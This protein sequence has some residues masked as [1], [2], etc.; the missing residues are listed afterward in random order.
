MLLC[1]LRAADYVTKDTQK[2]LE[3][4]SIVKVAKEYIDGHPSTAEDAG[5]PSRTFTYLLERVINRMAGTR[6]VPATMV[7]SY[8]LQYPAEWESARVWSVYVL[9]AI[10]DA[11]RGR[12]AAGHLDP[13]TQHEPPPPPVAAASN[14]QRTAAAIQAAVH[15]TLPLGGD[16]AG[17]GDGGDTGSGVHAGAPTTGLPGTLA[18]LGSGVGDD[19]F[20][21]SCHGLG[22]VLAGAELDLEHE[23]G[24]NGHLTMHVVPGEVAGSPD[25]DGASG[26]L[27]ASPLRGRGASVIAFSS[28]QENYAHRGPALAHLNFVEYVAIIGVRELS[29]GGPRGQRDHKGPGRVPNLEFPFEPGHKLA[30]TCVQYLLSLPTVPLLAGITPPSLV[31]IPALGDHSTPA[32]IAAVRRMRDELGA[33]YL[34]IMVPWATSALRA[35]ACAL[36]WDSFCAWVRFEYDDSVAPGCVRNS[37][38]ARA[39]REYVLACIQGMSCSSLQ[40]TALLSWR[41]LCADTRTSAVKARVDALG[42]TGGQSEANF[43]SGGDSVDDSKDGHGAAVTDPTKAK[44]MQSPEELRMC[45]QA[46][47]DH[48][49]L[50]MERL[51]AEDGVKLTLAEAQHQANVETALK[52]L[53]FGRDDGGGSSAGAGSGAGAGGGAQDGGPLP[54]STVGCVNCEVVGDPNVLYSTLKAKMPSSATALPEDGDGAGGAVDTPEPTSTLPPCAVGLGALSVQVAISAELQRRRDAAAATLN[55]GQHQ[56]LRMILDWYD[57]RVALPDAV[58]SSP[59]LLMVRGGPGSGKTYLANA[60][61]A[62]IDPT[63]AVFMAFTGV[64]ASLLPSPAM[65]VDAAMHTSFASGH[66]TAPLTEHQVALIAR[67]MHGKVILYLDEMSTCFTACCDFEPELCSHIFDAWLT[68]P[69]PSPVRHAVRREAGCCFGGTASSPWQATI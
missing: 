29:P 62:C 63:T 61:A 47:Q 28:Q 18:A 69:T 43:Y 64:A 10:A 65:T 8:L 51:C 56:V 1:V 5:S 21:G 33:F 49:L 39:R 14:V 31:N 24:G 12:K 19:A 53:N 15:G 44:A 22:A 46:Y 55:P 50:E 57:K 23:A 20:D 6:E 25:T 42:T 60:V 66:G 59:L 48:L 41:S 17:V 2:P 26:G 11:V 37:F 38:V 7:A 68:W 34:S 27:G 67:D 32:E 3:L 13:V 9:P 54:N 30:T 4:L 35:P 45:T 16:P 36:S 40:R 52:W 58:A